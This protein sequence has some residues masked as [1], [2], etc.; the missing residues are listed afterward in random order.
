MKWILFVWL[1]GAGN[2]F[3]GAI[4]IP[5]WYSVINFGVGAVAFFFA[6][7]AFIE[8]QVLKKEEVTRNESRS[9]S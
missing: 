1:L 6:H 7:F 8:L 3:L 9:G 2:W 5:H 4:S